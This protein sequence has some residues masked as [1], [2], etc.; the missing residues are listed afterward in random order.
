MESFIIL[1]SHL[2]RCP[3]QT[4]HIPAVFGSLDEFE[5]HWLA[6]RHEQA[7]IEPIMLDIIRNSGVLSSKDE[8]V[9]NNFYLEILGNPRVRDF[10]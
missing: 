5:E 9:I 3:V 8:G 4:S 2:S 10:L 1:L 6:A 7:K